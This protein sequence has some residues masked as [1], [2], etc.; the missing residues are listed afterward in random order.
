M[1]AAERL[2]IVTRRTRLE[3]LLVRFNTRSQARFFLERGGAEYADY[4]AEHETYH[5]SLDQLRRAL[6]LG[7]PRQF[8]DRTLA[9]SYLFQASDLVVTV[10]QDGLVAN[11]AKYATGIPIVAVNPD[12][13]RFDGVLLPFSTAEAG[14]VVQRALE[15]S[16]PVRRVTLA[17]AVL[18]DGQR[19]LAFNDLFVGARSHVSARYR[20]EVGGATELQSSSG[21]LV[22]TGAGSTGWMSSVFNMADGVAAFTGGA[23]GTPVRLA[24]EDGRLLFAVREPFRSRQSGVSVVAGLLPAGEPLRV[25]SRMPAGG[26]IFSDGME[27]DCLPFDAGAIAEIRAAARHAHLVTRNEEP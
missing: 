10:G 23:A 12:P 15:G 1:K 5:R 7:L 22:S 14:A 24:W 20:L 26:V 17:E 9:P 16:A 2:V 11:V 19:L 21:I 13:A 6:D 3:E 8:I 25:E 18:A 4:E 27:S